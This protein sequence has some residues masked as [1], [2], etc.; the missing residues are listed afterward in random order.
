MGN[1]GPRPFTDLQT[2]RAR[3]SWSSNK[4]PHFTVEK[5]ET[6]GEEEICLTSLSE[7]MNEMRPST[8]GYGAKSSDLCFFP[9]FSSRSHR[10]E[11]PRHLWLVSLVG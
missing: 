8:R 1:A 3:G 10:Y 2:A 11:F 7:L 4:P 9:H 6:Q 5:N